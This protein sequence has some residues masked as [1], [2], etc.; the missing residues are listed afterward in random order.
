MVNCSGCSDQN[1]GWQAQAPS[2]KHTHT[3]TLCASSK[4]MLRTQ[5][6]PKL[7][8]KPNT[9]YKE[10]KGPC[11]N[12]MLP[13]WW[14]LQCLV[15]HSS[16]CCDSTN[17]NCC[18]H[19]KPLPKGSEESTLDGRH[20]PDPARSRLRGAFVDRLPWCVHHELY[21]EQHHDGHHRP[22]TK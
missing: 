5:R 11:M 13:G 1:A 16:C 10:E 17:R 19:H 22:F 9:M 12:R 20:G 3:H 4:R 14:A 18:Q 21:M 15:A 6:S 7:L 2:C 8:V